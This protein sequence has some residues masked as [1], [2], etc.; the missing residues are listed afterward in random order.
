M[1]EITPENV[2]EHPEL[3]PEEKETLFAFNKRDKEVKIFTANAALM[4]RL[5]QHP[6]FEVVDVDW[7]EEQ[8]VGIK[9]FIP[10]NHLSV[11]G[12]GRQS[13]AQCNV[14]TNGVTQNEGQATINV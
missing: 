13:D 9:G 14:V 12:G 5:L 4:R 8:I 3:T 7:H 1:T 6:E 11:T 2:T 10:I